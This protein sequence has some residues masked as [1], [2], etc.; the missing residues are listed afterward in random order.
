[1]KLFC[2]G[3]SIIALVADE[4]PP[5]P[6]LYSKLFKNL[7]RQLNLRAYTGPFESIKWAKALRYDSIEGIE[8][9]DYGNNNSTTGQCSFQVFN[10]RRIY[11]CLRAS[12][13]QAN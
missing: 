7:P 1:M 9:F 6:I 11:H 8:R 12:K 13:V 2:G 5:L 4:R 10:N 3:Q